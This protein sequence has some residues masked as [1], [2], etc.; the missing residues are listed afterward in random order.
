[1]IPVFPSGPLNLNDDGTEI[2]Y[3][4]SHPVCVEKQND[5][6]SLKFRTRLTIGGDRIA[7]RSIP[8]LSPREMESLNILLNCMISEH[9]NLSTLDLT[10]FYLGTDLPHPEYIRIP[11]R[12][13]P[14]NVIEFYNLKPFVSGNALFCSVH[15]THYDLPQAGALS[16]QR[17]FQHLQ[18]HGYYPI[19]SSPSVFRNKTGTIRFTLVVDDFAVVWTNR[20]CMNHFV[21]T[22]TEL[23]QV[24]V[25]WMGT[26]Y[27]GM[28]ITIDRKQQHVTL[29][30]PGYIDKLLR[31]ACCPDGIKSAN[32]PAYYT[33]PNYSQH[34][35]AHKATVDA[36]P[37]A[38][39]SDKKQLQSVIGTLLYYSRA[40]DPSICTALHEL[41]SIQSKP[42]QN[43]MIK[44]NRLLGYVSKHR[45]IAIRY[46]ASNMVLQL[47]S[48]ASFLCRPMARSV[49]G[50]FCYL[51]E[52]GKMNGPIACASKM[53]T[54][55][56][57]SMA[58]AELCGGFKIAQDAVWY[59]RILHDLGYP[60]SS[61][62]YLVA[63]G[64]YRSHRLR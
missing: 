26:K 7:Y 42:T 14:E 58:E 61:T 40:V 18:N 6:G 19:P 38:S 27:L 50:A 21:H 31:K 41:G 15:K 47:L 54:S 3:R 32:T 63:N 5:D 29:S 51:G 8:R 57:A 28:D 52:P 11:L 13:I 59:R 9:A 48:D 45:N 44:M 12:L 4:K 46:Y 36:S 33:P 25:N 64:Q 23:Y 17:L 55:V 53:I 35:G 43:D 1:M 62:P 30:M 39:E 2:N 49:F 20:D 22:L 56:L 37:P 16:Q 10:D 24:K 60:Q 34:P